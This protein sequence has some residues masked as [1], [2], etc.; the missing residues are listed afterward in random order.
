MDCPRLPLYSCALHHSLNLFAV[1]PIPSPTLSALP[2]PPFSAPRLAPRILT[3][4][5][6]SPSPHLTSRHVTSP[7]L[8]SPHLTSPDLTSPRLASPRLALPHLASPCLTSPPPHL[9]STSPHLTSPRL[10]SPH[11]AS[12][13]LVSPHGSPKIALPG[14]VGDGMG[15]RRRRGGGS[16]N[17]LLCRALCFV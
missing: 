3:S 16:R 11:L 14:G 13:H 12:R 8:A 15:A 7:H 17:G 10:A 6:L 4:F 5:P 2:P 9:T 1:C